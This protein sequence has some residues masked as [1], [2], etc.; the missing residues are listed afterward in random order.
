MKNNN[1]PLSFL[2]FIANLAV[3]PGFLFSGLM[4]VN[5]LPLRHGAAYAVDGNNK[6]I[7][8]IIQSINQFNYN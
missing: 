5:I 2:R 8:I 6:N 3:T 4:M 7:E 1:L